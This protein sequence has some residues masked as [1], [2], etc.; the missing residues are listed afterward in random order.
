LNKLIR[1]L[2]KITE[3][4]ILKASSKTYIKLSENTHQKEGHCLDKLATTEG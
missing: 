4:T 2:R 3:I 1:L